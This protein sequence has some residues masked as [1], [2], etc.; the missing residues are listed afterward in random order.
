MAEIP[1]PFHSYRALY[2]DP[3]NNP[4]G[5]DD[6]TQERCYSAVFETFLDTH[7]HLSFDELL[8]NI[9]ADF[10]AVL[11]FLFGMEAPGWAGWISYMASSRNQESLTTVVIVW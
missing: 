6:E 3:A 4:F 7:V 2:G 11:A 8:H 5:L 9:L 10:H 1:H